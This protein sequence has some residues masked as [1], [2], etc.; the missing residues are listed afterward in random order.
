MTMGTRPASKI[1]SSFSEEWLDAWR[2]QLD[3]W[4][5]KAKWVE[6]QTKALQEALAM[7]ARELGAAQARPY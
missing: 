1:A 6:R 7:R 2:Q 4:I 3:Q 5:A